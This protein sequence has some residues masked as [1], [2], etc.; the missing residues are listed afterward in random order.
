[1]IKLNKAYK[2]RLYPN[3]E[4]EILINKTIGS[5]R[6]M[7][8][9]LLAERID[10]YEK[11]KHIE[12]KKQQR[13]ELKK[14]KQSNP[15]DFKKDYEWLKEVD[16]LALATAWTNVN[17][18]YKNFFNG[19]GFPKFKSKHK[20]KQTYTTYNQKGSISISEDNKYIKL[21]KLKEVRLKAHRQIKPTELIK[22]C[23]IS[24]TPSG[25]YYVSILVEYEKE[26]INK[27]I[28]EETQVVGLDFSMKDLYYSSEDKKAN[29]PRYYRKSLEKLAKEQRKL[30]RKVKGSKNREKQRI[31]VAKLHE[32][33]ANQRKDFLHKKSRELVNKF[34]AVIIEDLNMKAMGQCLNFGKS[35]SDNGWGM[36]TNFLGYKLLEE[37]KQL[38]KIDKWYPSSKTCSNCGC[39]KEKLGIEER[40]YKCEHCGVEID[41]D[42]NA[43]I[44]IKRVG[45]TQLAW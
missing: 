14:L 19:S 28:K 18:A 41:R 7:Y 39:I 37:G 9:Q 25:K 43:S 35:V 24:K 45:M 44:N 20:S 2:F 40:V 23:T 32:H 42:Y 21:P 15:S 4:Q 36:F 16:S 11:C 30:S 22:S 3:K 10:N 26:I 6:F 5:A 33:I 29:Y 17:K 8:N 27:E 13:L 1:M 34:D 31:K 38:I 12:D